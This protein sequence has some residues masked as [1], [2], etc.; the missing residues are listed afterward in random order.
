SGWSV[1]SGRTR[2]RRASTP[3]APAPATSGASRQLSSSSEESI[4]FRHLGADSPAQ[5]ISVEITCDLALLD[6]RDRARLLGYHHHERVRRKRGADRGA[7]PS[8]EP[9]AHDSFLRKRQQAAGGD[10]LV[11]TD[12]HG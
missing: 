3:P 2:P 5:A 4:A 10:D 1:G 7:V 6:D 8:S 11:A 12:D 9:L